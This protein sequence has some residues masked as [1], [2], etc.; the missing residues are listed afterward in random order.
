MQEFF[1]AA[2]THPIFEHVEKTLCCH[3]LTSSLYYSYDKMYRTVDYMSLVDL[4]LIEPCFIHK[5][6]TI[7]LLKKKVFFV[8]FFRFNLM[9]PLYVCIF[10]DS[11]EAHITAHNF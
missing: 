4:S 11:V 1:A 10:Y 7:N 5:K 8:C 6:F 3:Y 9:E 2:L